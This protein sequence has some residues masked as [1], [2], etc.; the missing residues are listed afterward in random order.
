MVPTDLHDF[1]IASVGAAAA[2]I[3]LL[4]VALTVVMGRSD[5]G[6]EIIGRDRALVASSYAALITILFISLVGLLPNGD[7]TWV[8]LSFGILGV[9]SSVR[10]FQRWL[11][12]R[13]QGDNIIMIII[14]LLLYLLLAGY[15]LVHAAH[16]AKLDL[17]I[18]S[19]AIFGLYGIALAR[20]WALI[21]LD[22]R[23]SESKR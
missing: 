20:A 18:F 7:V 6:T 13:N 2:F 16:P 12:D 1:L 4:F 17:N 21:G 15:G 3:G 23:S 9:F 14:S 19:T 11:K 8:M 22:R 10:L 5:A